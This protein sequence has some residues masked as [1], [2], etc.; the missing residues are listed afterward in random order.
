[1]M[2]PD[3]L[4]ATTCWVVVTLVEAEGSELPIWLL[5]MIW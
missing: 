1:M 4:P 2:V 5:A 3:N